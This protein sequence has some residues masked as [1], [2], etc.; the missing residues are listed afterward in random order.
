MSSFIKLGIFEREAKTPEINV[1]Q[2]ALLLCGEDPDTKTTEIPVDKKSAY[3]IYYRH[4]SKWLSASGLFRGGNQAPQQADYMFALAYPMIDEEITPE[5]IKIRCLK[6]VAYVA[7]R[8]NGKEHLFQMGGEDL[9]LKGIELSRNQRGLHRK[10]DE[11]DNTDKLIGL[12]VKLLAKK[13]GN[14]YGTIEE[15][16]ISK[17]YSELKILADEKNIS[18]AGISKSTVYKKISS[19]LQI[20]KIS[21]E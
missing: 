3:D 4:I 12:L 8:N 19:S 9:Y 7:S 1:K 15:P 21:D 6:A 11:R 14:S 5:P 18:M 2:L 20:L 17:I 16:T 13:L 10:D